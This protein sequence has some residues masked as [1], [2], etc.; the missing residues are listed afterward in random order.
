MVSTDS[1]W[2]AERML[3]M[4]CCDAGGVTLGTVVSTDS[5]WVGETMLM[6]VL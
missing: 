2:V 6:M 3:M 4:A 5:S 1:G